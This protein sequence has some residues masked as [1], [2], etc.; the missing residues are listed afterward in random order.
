MGEA[1]WLG[2][3]L[4]LGYAFTG[5]LEAASV[6]ALRILLLLGVAAVAVGLGLWL[7]AAI[8]ADPAGT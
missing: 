5:N 2:L 8:R 4:G 3:Y 7:R 6:F 1:V